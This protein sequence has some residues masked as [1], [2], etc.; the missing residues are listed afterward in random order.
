MLLHTLSA[1]LAAASVAVTRNI[2]PSG[3]TSPSHV[4][5]KLSAPPAGWAIDDSILLNKDTS[6]LKL[7]VQLV[8]QNIDKFHELAMNV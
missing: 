8:Q 6:M 5:E 1:V 7:R 2:P 4:Y 3:Y